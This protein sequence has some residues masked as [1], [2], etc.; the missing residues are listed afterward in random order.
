MVKETVLRPLFLLLFF[1]MMMTASMELGPNRWVPAVLESAGIPGILVLVWINL[2]MAILRFYAGPVV[3]RLSPTGILFASAIVSGLGLLWLSYTE[4]LAMALAAG[5]VF[6]VGVCYFWPT[7]LGV[8]SERVPKGGA[9]ALALMG[10]IGMAIVGLVTS[11]MMG[12][13]MDEHMMLPPDKTTSALQTVSATFPQLQATAKGRTGEDIA[14]A[15]KAANEVLVEKSTT[16][17]VPDVKTANALRSAIAAA[18]TSEAAQE[19]KA[20][21]GPAEN[22]GGQVA[23]RYVAPLSIILALIFGVLFFRDRAR[24]GYKVERLE[25]TGTVAPGSRKLEKSPT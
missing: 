24:G 2:L 15:L 6:A 10:G 20:V 3:H 22:K 12:K 21:L 7:M 1:C 14:A 25:A 11:P 4:S 16:G 9:L 13:I 5:T 19:A 18:P 8:T 23:F 17:T